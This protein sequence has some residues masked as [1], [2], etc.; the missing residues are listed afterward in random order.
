MEISF[1]DAATVVHGMGFG[2]V[3]LL[4]FS[5]A[6]VAILSLSNAAQPASE[7]AGDRRLFG[8]YFAIMALLAWVAVFA[9]AYLIYPWYRAHP[10]AGT[11][12][13]ASFP[14]ALLT[15]S[16]ATSGWH[17]IG[18]EW[19]EHV[20]WLSPICL[21]AVTYVVY[22]YGARLRDLK[23]LRNATAGLLAVAFF[24]TGVA[25]FFCA[26]LNKYAPVRGGAMI[27]LM[28]ADAHDK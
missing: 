11:T 7:G 3:L 19:K 5:G 22:R 2:A 16:P 17:D 28:K 18:M 12:D 26:M 9:G 27:V 21:T 13:L 6:A 10:P 1:R 4:L 15:S 23:G 8:A 25:G 14:K 24:A 20:A